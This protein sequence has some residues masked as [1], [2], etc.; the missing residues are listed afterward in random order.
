MTEGSTYFQFAQAEA[1]GGR[2]K[3]A[4][5]PTHVVGSGAVPVAGGK[6]DPVPAEPALSPD[7]NPAL[8]PSM[9]LSAV[10]AQV[11]GA[12]VS[13]DALPSGVE[14]DTGAPRFRDQQLW[15]GQ[16]LLRGLRETRLQ[17]E[18]LRRR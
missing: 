13:G 11:A 4:L 12:S 17:M 9:V 18:A 6:R 10:D 16:S 14:R 5:G 7:E 1:L 8:E 15:D 3:D 2:F